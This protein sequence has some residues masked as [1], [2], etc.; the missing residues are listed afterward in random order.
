[1][2]M[3]LIS[4]GLMVFTTCLINAQSTQKLPEFALKVSEPESHLRFLAADE[5]LGRRTGEPGNQKAAEYIADQFKKVGAKPAVSGSYFQPVALETIYPS[6]KGTITT[7]EGAAQ[8]MEDFVLMSGSGV[9]LQGAEIV[10]LPYG[11]VDASTGYDDYA[12]LDVRNKVV[13]VGVGF[14]GSNSPQDMFGAMDDK[15]KWAQEK[16]AKAII[17]VFNSPIPW[18][19]IAG[20]FGRKSTRLVSKEVDTFPHVWISSSAAKILAKN[21]VT[22]VNIAIEAPVSKPLQ[23]S[24]VIGIIEGTDPVLKNEYV[25]LS[26]H[27]DHVGTGKENGR[28]TATD[29]IFNGARDNAFGTTAILTA[30]KALAQEKTKRSILLIAYTG[31]EIGLLGSKFYAENPVVPLQQCVYNLN[32]DGAGYNDTSL[33]TVIGLSRTSGEGALLKAAEAFGLK[34]V[35][36]SAPE[37]NLFDRSDNVSLAAKGIPAPTYSPG[38]TAFDDRINQYYHQVADEADSVDFGYLLKYCQSYTYAARLIANEVKAPTW[39]SG[40][41]YEK[42][43]QKLY[44]K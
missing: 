44:A 33:I 29:T 1:M 21:K 39:K 18:R 25:V 26:A 32:C 4:T 9:Q 35:E 43:F 22:Q 38:F 8:V 31:E 16:G 5:L 10:Y 24:N 34:A 11:W 37:Q 36:D 42:A 40:D 7:T 14:P 41:K 2:F 19:N 6:T 23:S 30:A 20:Y 15:A 17:E 13:V 12:G 3:R 28:V 27:Y